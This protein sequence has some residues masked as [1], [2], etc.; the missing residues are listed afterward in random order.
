MY[1]TIFPPVT[2]SHF[3]TYR[4]T[5]LTNDYSGYEQFHP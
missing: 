4:F 2:V 1:T 5:F 3:I